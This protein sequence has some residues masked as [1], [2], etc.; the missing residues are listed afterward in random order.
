M[1]RCAS[2]RHWTDY[3]PGEAIGLC[4][5]ISTLSEELGV[6]VQR[7]QAD[8]GSWPSEFR[9]GPEF[10][11]TLHEPK[12]KREGSGEPGLRQR[13]LGLIPRIA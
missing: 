7:G 2:C 12:E 4:I 3:R 5:Q 9:T 11:C 10:G 8:E 13:M 6:F 1:N